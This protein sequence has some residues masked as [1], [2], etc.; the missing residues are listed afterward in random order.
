MKGKLHDQIQLH[1][2]LFFGRGGGRGAC[3]LR[4]APVLCSWRFTLKVGVWIQYFTMAECMKLSLQVGGTV[5]C[6]L[7]VYLEREKQKS[8]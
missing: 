1:I 7:L 3:M 2:I 5:S 8:F 6:Y 4:Q